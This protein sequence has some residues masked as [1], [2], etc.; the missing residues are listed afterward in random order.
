MKGPEQAANGQGKRA[1]PP[2]PA[3]RAHRPAFAGRER[4]RGAAKGPR[5]GSVVALPGPSPCLVPEGRTSVWSST[6]CPMKESPRSRA[7]SPAGWR[8]G[9]LTGVPDRMGKECL[10]EL[11]RAP[12]PGH[13]PQLFPAPSGQR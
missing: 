5:A 10:V 4:S 12:Y 7:L 13:L 3:L 9:R 2:R 6:R 8:W 1:V 11:H